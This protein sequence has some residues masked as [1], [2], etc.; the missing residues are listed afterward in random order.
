MKKQAVRRQTLRQIWGDTDPDISK[1]DIDPD[2]SKCDLD[3]D[4]SK[5][6]IDPDIS[7]C[8]IDPDASKCDTHP[9]IFRSRDT[10]KESSRGQRQQIS[11]HIPMIAS[12]RIFL[13]QQAAVSI[14]DRFSHRFPCFLTFLTI[15]CRSQEINRDCTVPAF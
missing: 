9:D 4:V 8:D 11:V 7:K 5:F 10:D 12:L 15:V 14:T 1:C 6:D 13:L 3:P 2:V